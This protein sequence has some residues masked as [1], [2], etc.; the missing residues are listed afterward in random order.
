MPLAAHETI[1]E[2]FR[3]HA[4]RSPERLMMSCDHGTINAVR[5]LERVDTLA[6]YLRSATGRAGVAYVGRDERDYLTVVLAC[7]K[8]GALLVV[9]VGDRRLLR[10]AT[11]D[12]VGLTLLHSGDEA[13]PHGAPG[14]PWVSLQE[15]ERGSAPRPS[16]GPAVPD[17]V[18]CVLYTSGTTGAPLGVMTT[19]ASY[20]INADDMTRALGLND[21]DSFVVRS[22][23]DVSYGLSL[24]LVLP[25]VLGVSIRVTRAI[26]PRAVLRA[27]A[28]SDR[29]A[30]VGTP[31]VY[32]ELTTFQEELRTA[33]A[34]AA[35]CWFSSGDVLP[36]E[37]HE[38]F[39]GLGIPLCD[40]YGSTE[41]NGIGI[42]NGASERSFQ[43][44]PSVQIRLDEASGEPGAMEGQLLVRG[45]KVMRGY[46]GQGVIQAQH[47][48]LP[49]GW[50][51]T[52]DWVRRNG[53][54]RFRL[55][56][57]DASLIKVGGKR[58]H[59]EEVERALERI[60]GVTC[61]VAYG[62][63]DPLHGEVLAALIQPEGGQAPC[64]A[65]IRRRLS[66]EL[67]AHMIPRRIATAD[68]LST[69]VGKKRRDRA[70]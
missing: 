18:W 30:V 70:H 69:A 14:S 56:G 35:P 46:Y 22:P 29:P 52:L 28:E 24:G 49:G 43:R 41:T 16:A 4:H 47:R 1:Y 60:P 11:D 26:H 31:T 45:P 57:R 19:E 61:A 40:C 10:Q 2:V 20:L 68:D 17:D 8:A 51:R 23:L 53:C 15:V 5:L 9:G 63:A 21:C 27:V 42:A 12:C 59:A 62:L 32:R 67:P 34:H 33:A 50:I 66:V 25:L 39:A 38:R 7:S 13:P 48:E 58:V 64:A 37:V 36:A 54:D 6:A 55:L 65:D 3:E 44:L